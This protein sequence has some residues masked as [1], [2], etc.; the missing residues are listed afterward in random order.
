[1]LEFDDD[2]RLQFSTSGCELMTRKGVPDLMGNTKN[3]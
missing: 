2:Y 1:V 3:R